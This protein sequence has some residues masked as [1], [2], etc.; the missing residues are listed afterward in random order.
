MS[1]AKTIFVLLIVTLLVL[2][3]LYE[4]ADIGEQ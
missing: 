3:P 1:R 4:F 2:L